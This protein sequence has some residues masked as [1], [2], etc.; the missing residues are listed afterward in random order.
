MCIARV[1]EFMSSLLAN[2]QR[3]PPLAAIRGFSHWS[4]WEDFMHDMLLG[5]GFDLVGSVIVEVCHEGAFHSDLAAGGWELILNSQLQQA[6]KEFQ[7]FCAVSGVD[8]SQPLFN[9][10]PL[11]MQSSTDLP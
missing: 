10:N 4:L 11:Q 2:E 7:T 3:P 8:C 6:F 1:H 5:L 9:T